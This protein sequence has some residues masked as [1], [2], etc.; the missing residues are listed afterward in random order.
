AVLLLVAVRVVEARRTEG[1]RR[2][3]VR[4]E[5]VRGSGEGDRAGGCAGAKTNRSG[6][7]SASPLG[8]NRSP[9]QAGR[10]SD[11]E[12]AAYGTRGVGEQLRASGPGILVGDLGEQGAAVEREA[13]SQRDGIPERIEGRARD[14]NRIDP[15][16]DERVGRRGQRDHGRYVRPG[17]DRRAGRS[18]ERGV[19]VRVDGADA[20]LGRR[21]LCVS[22]A[23]TRG[24]RERRNR[25]LE[26][27]ARA[28]DALE[29]GRWAIG[30]ERERLG[31]RDRGT[32]PERVYN[33]HA[34]RVGDAGRELQGIGLERDPVGATWG[35]G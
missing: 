25:D 10:D 19:T 30:P 13:L 35:N 33:A 21:P 24:V 15:I 9:A 29:G 17:E 3:A 23:K 14:E 18:E 34:D 2:Q 5:G 6:A 27:R 11:P 8:L 20:P 1:Q 26:D 4:R 16:G 32:I 31:S 22:E 28:R 12:V 7:G